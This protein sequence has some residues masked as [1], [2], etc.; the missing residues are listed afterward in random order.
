MKDG[1]TVTQGD[2]LRFSAK[3]NQSGEYWC[4]AENGLG[5]NITATAS[6][7]VQFAPSLT[8]TPAD[9]TVIEG[10]KTTFHCNASG[11]PSPKITWSKDGKTVTEGETL[12]FEANRNQSGEYWCSAENGLNVTVNASVHLDVQFAPSFT[13]IPSDLTVRE[14]NEVSFHCSATG[15]P[16]PTIT[17]MKD[18]MTVAS[19]NVLR[20]S[21]K[22]NQ[23]GVYHCSAV[24]G[25]GVN[26]TASASLDVQFAPSL[27]STPADQTV[28]EGTKT[29][30]YCNASGNPSPKITWSKDGK[31]VTEGETLSFEFCLQTLTMIC[32]VSV[33]PSLVKTPTNKTIFEGETATFHCTATGNPVPEITWI[34]DG[35]TVGS[36]E[37]L[38]FETRRNQSGKYWC[39]ADNGIDK[40]A[41][42]SAYLN[43]HY[44]LSLTTTPSDQT[45]REGE[46]AEFHC[47]ATG[48]P[49]P[50]VSWIKDGEAVSQG[51]KLS[52]ETS[53]DQSG[54]YWCKARNELGLTV[55]ASAL[56]NVLFSPTV[57]TK[58]VNKTVTEGTMA[59]F[60]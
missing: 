21:T 15:N 11:N 56:L 33:S 45:V 20:F 14:G 28:I 51:D 18:G 47:S 27:I 13:V 5:V 58:P 36:G 53:K 57:D 17:W 39:S 34:K 8:S 41:N 42:A 25:L 19:G 9:Q 29:T 3:R 32:L 22:R 1:K 38:S 26:I 52:F 2:T 49:P 24:N 59:T 60:Y 10:T 12:S 37:T 31:T 16:T 30:F 23:S 44:P 48:N 7:N 43:V 4:L 50:V 55:N 54:K 35:K 46:T 6:L 40:A